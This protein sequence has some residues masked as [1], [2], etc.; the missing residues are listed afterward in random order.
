MRIK[1][2][3]TLNIVRG[4]GFFPSFFKNVFLK[5]LLH[6]PLFFKKQESLFFTALFFL[7]FLC[8]EFILYKKGGVCYV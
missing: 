8:P 5:F 7:Q 3:Y 6:L 2:I 4:G 1:I